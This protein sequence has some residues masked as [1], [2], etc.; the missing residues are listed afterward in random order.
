MG[1]E[2]I[3]RFGT[4]I[5]ENP[6][7]SSYLYFPL[8]NESGIMG[9]ITPNL[10]GD[11]KTGQNSFLLE[12]VSS[13]GLHASPMVRNIW[14]SIR[15]GGVWSAAGVSASQLARQYEADRDEVCL[16]AG[17]LWQ[18]VR[19]KSLKYGISADVLSFSP[20][21]REKVEIM[22]VTFSNIS[23]RPLSFTPTIA[24]PIY[25]RSA[26]NIRD[27]R[28]VTSLLHRI[29]VRD[30]G[31]AVS[32]TL[33]FDAR[34]HRINHTSYG[35]FAKGEN[36]ELPIGF[37]PT[38]EDFIG[39][40]GSLLWPAAVIKD[41]A[42]MAK[43]GDSFEGYEAMGGIRFAETVLHP[44][45][46]KSY[47]VILNYNEEGMDYLN[48][49]AAD[50]AYNQMKEYWE[51]Q[52]NIEIYSADKNF[53]RW[54]GWVGIQPSLR[55]IYG[56]SF[57]PH[58]DYGRGG[59]G[60][61]DLWQDCLALLLINPETV[62]DSLVSYLGGV[63]MDG[64]NATIIGKNPGEFKADRNSIV[65]V[66][67]DHGMWPLL[68]INLY[69]QQTGDYDIL[70]EQNTYFKDG[71]SH[72]GDRMDCLW[73]ENSDRLRTSAGTVYRGTILEHLLVQ[74]LSAFYDVGSHNHMRLRTGDWN[75]A[76]DMARDK[77]ESVAFTAAYG[78]NM[79]TLAT[80]LR[81]AGNVRN[82]HVIEVAEELEILIGRLAG[83]NLPADQKQDRLRLYF[84]KCCSCVSG[85]KL[86]LSI[87]ELADDLQAKGEWIQ[88]H[89]RN[90]EWL[91][92]L[93][94]HYWFNGYYDNDGNPVEGVFRDQVRVMLTGQVF[95]IMSKT[96]TDEQVDQIVKTV[97]QYLY[98]ENVGGYRL[99]TNFREVKINLGRLFGFAYGNKENGSVFSH[100][101]VMYAYSLYTRGFVQE[102]YKVIQALY[103]HVMDFDSSRCYPGI[104]EYFNN[105]GRG[106]YHYLTGSA[107]WLVFTVL[108]EMFGVRGERGNLKI[109]PRLLGEQFN[110][111][112]KA[113]IT[114]R[115]AKRDL[116]ITFENR[117]HKEIGDYGVEEILVDRHSI[118][119]DPE[120]PVIDRGIINSL[121]PNTEH[122]ITIILA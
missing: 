28:H 67:M 64:S 109:Q 26:D 112:G 39:E 45:N 11:S 19:R 89:I 73:D 83:V 52:T 75:E 10:G 111:Q 60:W 74:Q 81:E 116:R 38:L 82:T 22:K 46:V 106:M 61:R 31:V 15:D 79:L 84:N 25:G 121:L 101:A 4:F 33:S 62:R 97:D 55:K 77:G 105:K 43:E 18:M 56:C 5:L 95:T 6:Q 72:K 102:G 119:F 41:N 66:W 68:A 99:N 49:F 2:F 44:G 16:A 7:D 13:E 48:G 86:E 100:M 93:D 113:R 98:E 118:S 108:T 80:L 114:C 65:R 107:S 42:P 3:D 37:Y 117:N 91:S 85:K 71:I 78:G 63:R 14:C 88:K 94:G 1:F 51:A 122:M 53:D 21:T 104:P 24:V 96:A 87:S 47:Y 90:T 20:A 115:F 23:E 70:F 29:S 50:H 8:T 32:P 34:G 9:S 27:H 17:K 57:L 76:L 40:G 58:H 36:N 12:P 30:C 92:D 69:I 35:V 110:S 59:R 120:S 54:M 103:K